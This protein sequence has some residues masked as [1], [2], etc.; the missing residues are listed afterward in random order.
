M[1][2]NYKKHG[3]VLMV[4]VL[5]FCNSIIF[6]IDFK[7]SNRKLTFVMMNV[8]QGD[9]L[10]IES[11]TGTQIIVDGG[12]GKNILKELP[13]FMPFWDR[14]IDAV[15][16]TNPDK[17]HIS[18]FTDI[19]KLYKVDTVFEP[20]T[21]NDSSTY[22]NLEKE[23]KNQDIPNI[24]AKKGM[25]I[26]IGGGAYLE[27]LFPDRDVSMREVNDGSIVMR[28]IYGETSIMLTGD[29]TLKTEKIILNNEK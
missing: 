4:L 14:S 21:M 6:Y 23:I 7:Y 15:V 17:D 2:D 28:L 3:L 25:I 11:P 12:P 16:I 27:V 22:K 18:G 9:A 5:I 10:F 26:D 19:L 20:G 8:G 29:A 24:L 13:K 1:V